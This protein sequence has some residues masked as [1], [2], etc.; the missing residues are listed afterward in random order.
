MT[1]IPVTV[2]SAMCMRKKLL[3]EELI[4]N[5]SDAIYLG[6][7]KLLAAEYVGV[8]VYSVMNWQRLGEDEQKWIES[9]NKPRKE[10]ALYL[11]FL[12]SVN[13]AQ[14]A[15]GIELLQ[16]IQ[17]ARKKKDI[18]SSWRMLASKYRDYAASN[19]VDLT[20]G[21]NPLPPVTR[22]EIVYTPTDDPEGGDK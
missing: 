10:N 11:K 20:S 13:E 1:V 22:I 3:T 2:T 6:A 14:A 7:T 5:F 8:S 4:K 12:Q 21:G 18:N 16:E 9:G 19:S 15:L 17:D